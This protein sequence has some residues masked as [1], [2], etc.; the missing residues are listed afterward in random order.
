MS[1]DITVSVY[2]NNT[3]SSAID[4]VFVRGCV[5]ALAVCGFACG[6]GEVGDAP[7]PGAPEV[8]AGP[9][10]GSPD[11][12]S[13]P[14]VDAGS[15]PP[16][17][18]PPPPRQ[19]PDDGSALT[20][21]AY[22]RVV[23]EAGA[24][25]IGAEVD[26]GAGGPLITDDRGEVLVAHYRDPVVAVISAAGFLSEPVVV[27]HL[28]HA[29]TVT[30]RL[31]ADAGGTRWAM[32]AAGDLML[33][34]RFY[35]GVG[36]VGPLLDPG[37]LAASA[38]YVVEPVARAFAA[39][40]VKTVNVETILSTLPASA[41]YP[42]KGVVI[43]SHPDTVA[44]LESL[45]VSVA[46]LG[47]NHIFDYLSAGLTATVAALEGAGIAHVGAA[48]SEATA[49][50]P[51]FIDVGPSTA[52]VRVGLLSYS[53]Q[54][55]TS[56]NDGY[57]LDGDPVPPDLDP[58]DAFRYEAR[59]WQFS[60]STLSVPAAARRIGSAWQIF[61]D[62]E[63]GMDAAEVAA[64]WSSMYAVYP[65]LQDYVARRGHGGAAY[66]TSASAPGDISAL[67]ATVDLVVVQVHGGAEF[68]S[69]PS[70]QST[71]IARAAIDAGA[72]IVINHHPHILQGFEWYRGGLIAYSMGNFVFDQEEHRATPTGFLRTV[73][74][75][76]TLVEARLVP[77]DLGGYRP[78]PVS[79]KIAERHVRSL[80][81]QSLTAAMSER[82]SAGVF[83]P[84][85]A[86][87][88]PESAPVH[89]RM[90]HHDAVI[91]AAAPAQETRTVALAGGESRALGE[92]GLWRPAANVVVSATVEL[93]REL[94]GWGGF[95]DG[96]SDGSDSHALHWQ[97]GH[98]DSELQ[99]DPLGAA[100]GVGY[101]TLFR[102]A[103]NVSDANV[104]P[105]TRIP[106]PAHRLYRNDAGALVPADG[107]ARYTIRFRARLNGQAD[108]YV[109]VDLYEDD[110]IDNSR[111]LRGEVELPVSLLADGG[112]HQIEVDIPEGALD[113]GG[114]RMGAMR[115]HIRLQAPAVGDSELAVDDVRVIEW[116]P[117][118]EAPGSF[119]AYDY[120]RNLGPG[121][122]AIALDFM[123]L[124]DL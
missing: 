42:E 12:G 111:G 78:G 53:T 3:V 75:R 83:Q 105:L 90:R 69:A 82:D 19:V 116:R 48:D 56:K 25:V 100:E 52:P 64:A 39:A 117:A 36:A 26:I 51:L 74:D 49:N 59:V 71:E 101:A 97:L 86:A 27:G 108:V 21:A 93:G 46:I 122:D 121:E 118:V 109:R 24:A 31:F 123:P 114:E 17:P 65:E 61:R 30:V 88:P 5:T 2:Q 14:T 99:I 113:V 4:Y 94:F 79:D 85:I 63:S 73:W 8:D 95:E 96:V 107:S 120:V 84:V 57:P 40:D 62:A 58:E 91:T 87:L 47:N 72:D 9:G 68:Q 43:N 20:S 89:L 35:D 33:T 28:D 16:P 44:A 92:V 22:L 67:A 98:E 104:V 13:L 103:T 54:S 34:R 32:H 50:Q 112:W 38:A 70:Q 18:P 80:W 15:P 41:G 23:D 77:L 6:G 119:A 102:D 76:D 66:W 55:G 29:Q 1:Y 7:T 10:G 11:A 37:D 124:R 115:P 60:G 110:G 106:L 45:E 81:E